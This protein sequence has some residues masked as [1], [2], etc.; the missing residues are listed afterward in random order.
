M[1]KTGQ[2]ATAPVL[3]GSTGAGSPQTGP[4]PE[5]KPGDKPL[6]QQSEDPAKVEA[7]PKLKLKSEHR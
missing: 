2:I 7:A 6:E 5:A 4:R 1:N 3:I